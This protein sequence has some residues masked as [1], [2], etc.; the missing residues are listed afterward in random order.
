LLSLRPL[1]A[2]PS[3]T[4]RVPALPFTADASFGADVIITS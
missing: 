2:L 1:V 3:G 4:M